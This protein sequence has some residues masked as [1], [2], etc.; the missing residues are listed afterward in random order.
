MIKKERYR[1]LCYDHNGPQRHSLVSASSLI[2]AKRLAWA[3]ASGTT[4]EVVLQ[5]TEGQTLSRRVAIDMFSGFCCGS[6][7]W[8][9]A[10][11]RK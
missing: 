7:P 5:D 8:V 6:R 10:H 1:V 9:D 3:Y 2:G 11:E 4:T